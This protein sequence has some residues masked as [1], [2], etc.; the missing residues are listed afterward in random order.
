MAQAFAN[1][2]GALARGI[3]QGTQLGLAVRQQRQSEDRDEF[4]RLQ[5]DLEKERK[6]QE[7]ENKKLEIQYDF[8]VKTKNVE[9]ARGIL[10]QM[11]TNNGTDL[12][13]RI[14]DDRMAEF[15]KSMIE[16]DKADPS[17]QAQLME[18]VID[19]YLLIN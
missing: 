19:K 13:L 16:L 12:A 18:K 1:P 15:N 14:D 9:A 2:F 5:G 17:I 3:S 8:F 7:V 4:N 6:K 11:D 10:Q